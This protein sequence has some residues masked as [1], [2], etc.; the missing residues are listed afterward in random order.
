MQA[1]SDSRSSAAGALPA[2]AAAA[3]A[4]LA[5]PLAAEAA[6]AAAAPPEDPPPDAAEAAAAPCNSLRDEVPSLMSQSAPERKSGGGIIN[7]LVSKCVT[8]VP[9]KDR[10]QDSPRLLT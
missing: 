3:D 10:L 9:S 6:E 7:C 2:A 8:A 1:T 4:A 5:A